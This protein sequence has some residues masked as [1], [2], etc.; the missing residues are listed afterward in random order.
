MRRADTRPA[1]RSVGRL[2]ASLVGRSIDK[3]TNLFD[4]SRSL[5]F[6]PHP[7]T[8]THS[9][10]CRHRQFRS[11]TR[12]VR[13]VILCVDDDERDKQTKQFKCEKNKIEKANYKQQK[14]KAKNERRTNWKRKKRW[15]R[16]PKILNFSFQCRC[17]RTH[18]PRTACVRSAKSCRCKL[19]HAFIIICSMAEVYGGASRYMP[20]STRR[21]TNELTMASITSYTI[22]SHRLVI[23]H[24]MMV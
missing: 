21:I 22:F 20:N 1:G 5:N 18:Q 12:S 13:A 15:R 16:E 10:T 3:A 11:T 24:F 17:D 7:L 4:Y 2:P 8:R 14:E 6:H 9:L 23:F 19:F